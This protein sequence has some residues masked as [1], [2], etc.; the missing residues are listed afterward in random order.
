MSK[1]KNGHIPLLL[2]TEYAS[3]RDGVIQALAAELATTKRIVLY[4][5]MAGTAPLLS[6]AEKYGH[7]AYFNDLNSLHFYVNAAKTYRSYLSFVETGSSKL[8]TMIC[9]M[10]AR[11]DSCRRTA[12]DKWIEPRVLHE[13][14]Q[15]WKMAE[16]ESEEIC[17]LLKAV[18]LLSLRDFS[19]FTRTKNPTWFK[20][21]GLRPKI[22]VNDAFRKAIKRIEIFYEYV[23][24]KN[25][26]IVGGQI[27]LS[28]YDASRFTPNCDV[29]A[30][31]TSPPYCN[32]VD[33]DRLY[34]PE[35]FFLDAVGVWHIRTEFLGTTAVHDYPNFQSDLTFVTQ[36]SRYLADFLEEV[37]KRQIRHE[38]ES[39]YYVKYFT[40]YFA[41]LFKVFNTVSG[42]L[43]ARSSG[44]YIAVQDNVHRGLLIEIGKAISEFLSTK[45]FEAH[46]LN[47]SWDRHHLGLQNISKHYRLVRPKQQESI[48]HAVR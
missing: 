12:T 9:S 28:D 17:V 13:L 24:S 34:A 21:G 2:P 11:I 29:D 25:P 3:Y 48:W 16:S 40:R 33:W 14:V 45:G 1:L 39:N 42:I 32:R 46:P 36:H 20:P 27:I 8:H 44:I 43:S 23:Y 10:T 22:S 5:P 7:N 15:G 37:R 31:M 35:H 26:D 30:V 18:I 41:G 4:D 6:F 19:S 38:R 47:Q